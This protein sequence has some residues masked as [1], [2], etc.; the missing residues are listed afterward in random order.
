V[1][2]EQQLEAAL[3]G[4]QFMAQHQMQRPH[5]RGPVARTTDDGEAPA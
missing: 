5:R 4:L 3:D 1:T 2:A